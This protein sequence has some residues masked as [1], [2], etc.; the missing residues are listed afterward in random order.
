M[1][2]Q[3][4][5]IAGRILFAATALPAQAAAEAGL[6][7][8]TEN[9]IRA[10][11]AEITYSVIRDRFEVQGVVRS[12]FHNGRILGHVDVALVDANGA[13]LESGRSELQKIHH[14]N[15]HHQHRLDFK[16][17]FNKLPA[18]ATTLRVRHHIGAEGS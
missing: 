14:A 4:L 9:S 6:T 8:V 15:K 1:Y 18:D 2:Q 11:P 13:V 5:P 12:R 3:H 7:I 16:V 17:L 10:H